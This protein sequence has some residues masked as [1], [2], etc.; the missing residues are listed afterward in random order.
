MY[1]P[2]AVPP[3]AVP[4]SHFLSIPVLMKKTNWLK[5]NKSLPLI[6]TLQIILFCNTLPVACRQLPG[7]YAFEN[8]G[9]LCLLLVALMCSS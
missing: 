6:G 9:K 2:V 5:V 1:T 8:H 3:V 4:Q 7:S